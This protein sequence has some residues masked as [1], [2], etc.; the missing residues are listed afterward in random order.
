MTSKCIPI[1]AQILCPSVSSTLLHHSL[2]V[3][4][5]THS[6]TASKSIST[7][8][9]SQ[10]LIVSATSDIRGLQVHSIM[11]LQ[12]IFK[13]V[14]PLYRSLCPFCHNHSLHVCNIMVQLQPG[15]V[16]TTRSGYVIEDRHQTHLMTAFIS[17]KPSFHQKQPGGRDSSDGSDGTSHPLF[18]NYILPVAQATCSLANRLVLPCNLSAVMYTHC[19]NDIC[20]ITWQGLQWCCIDLHNAW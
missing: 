2:Q 20:V 18:E 7:H 5:Q 3:H 8:A 14:Q 6:I 10:L 11:A 16:S 13:H 9:Q 4:L 15:N 19:Q 12:W 17:K 1:L